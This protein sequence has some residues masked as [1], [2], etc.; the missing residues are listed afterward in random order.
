M[1]GSIRKH[2]S[3][4]FIKIFLTV[5]ALAFVICFGMSDIIR[6]VTGKDYVLK[7]GKYK[8]SPIEFKFEKSQK[9][10]MLRGNS[11]DE[12][13]QTLYLLHQLIWDNLKDQAAQ[14][15]GFL[16]SDY[17]I[18][19]YISG[20]YE[21]RD[22]S[23][24]FDGNM[25]RR[26]LAAIKLPEPAFIELS[27][28]NIQ[29]ALIRFPFRYV[30]VEAEYKGYMTSLL[31]KRKVGFIRIVPG[32]FKIDLTPSAEELEEFYSNHSD[33]FM[34]EE[35]RSFKLLTLKE[36]D[37]E[38]K[39]QISEDDIK[40]AYEYSP[41]KDLKTF[42]EL[43]EELILDLKNERLQN[44]ID[45]LTRQIEDE[46]MNK[47]IIEVSK[48]FNLDVIEVHDVNE[49]NKNAQNKDVISVAFKDDVLKT[50]FSTEDGSES[51][52]SESLDKK[53]R[54]L[55]LVHIDKIVPKHIKPFEEVKDQVKKAWEKEK[56]HEAAFELA[57]KIT[58]S[59]NKDTAL[60]ELAKTYSRDYQITDDFNR[61]GE[62]E[63]PK[64]KKDKSSK[65]ENKH[66][67]F[68]SEIFEDA[69]LLTKNSASYKEIKGE[70]FVYQPTDLIYTEPSDKKLRAS[71]YRELLKDTTDD[72]YQQLISY[73]S[74]KYEVKIN[75]DVLKEIN[76][77][78][79]PEDLKGI[80]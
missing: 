24:R 46:L 51:P 45:E 8:I 69:F 64:S 27:R 5:L 36:S 68:I 42:D 15:F 34:T 43:K 79:D 10:E 12:K 58:E 31:E 23:G 32:S 62:I 20:M 73:L 50:A 21:F 57:K 60:S 76:E 63:D 65:I 4:I 77:E 71:Y 52:F 40:D 39:I 49:F 13:T 55:W 53:E 26:F 78:I 44:E 59:V 29:E 35:I 2:S 33:L 9:R 30:S 14:G 7:V 70:Y 47:D 6:R 41:E 25:L 3:S 11:V 66:A 61:V 16:V 17:T 28:R 75:F 74:K 38:K 18:K 72:L 54:I 48:N 80:F 37:I 1:L 67:S 19:D 22:R 56:Q